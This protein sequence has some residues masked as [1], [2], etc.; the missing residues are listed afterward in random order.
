MSKRVLAWF[1]AGITSAVACKLALESAG[2]VEI[3]YFDIASAHPDNARFIEECQEWFEQKINI[4]KSDKYTDQFDV[5]EKTRYINGP[6]GARCTAELKR[7]VREKIQDSGFYAQVFGFEYEQKEINRAIRF[8]EQNPGTKPSFP[9]IDRRLT[10]DA[11]A[12]ILL[13]NGIEIPVMYRM[14]YPNNN[15]IGCVKGGQ[16]YWN[17]IRSDF[18]ESFLKM[19]ELERD[20]G[21]TCLRKDDQPLYLDELDPG[22]GRKLKI[23]MPDCGS[24]CQIEF[25][26]LISPK[27]KKV[28]SGEESI[29]RQLSFGFIEADSK[30]KARKTA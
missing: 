3:W 29:G 4:A 25:A 12:E 26:D 13:R 14:G 17:K 7:A 9:L 15:C 30:K 8:E 2:N 20:L 1:S 23:V 11:C 18:P 27:V 19:A 6:H 28:M 10:K 21:H 24:F 5:I 22:A 16:G